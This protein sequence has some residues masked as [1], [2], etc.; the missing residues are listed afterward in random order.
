MTA[1][2]QAWACLLC[3]ADGTEPGADLAAR[4]HETATGHATTTY[5]VGGPYDKGRK[6]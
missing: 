5:V 6:A 3:E 2:T 4:K 1:L